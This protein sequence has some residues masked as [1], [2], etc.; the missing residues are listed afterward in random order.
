MLIVSMTRTSIL[1]LR[2]FGLV[3]SLVFLTY[4]LL[5]EAYPIAVVN[6]VIAALRS[7]DA[8]NDSSAGCLHNATKTPDIWG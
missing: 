4:S 1:K 6:V 7:T 2:V 5:I 8:P 3:G